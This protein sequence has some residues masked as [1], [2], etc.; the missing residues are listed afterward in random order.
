MPLKGNTILA[1][2]QVMPGLKT[3]SNIKSAVAST[4]LWPGQEQISQGTRL[5]FTHRL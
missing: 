2:K 4:S 1:I 3:T 5:L